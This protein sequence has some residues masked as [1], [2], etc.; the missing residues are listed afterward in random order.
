MAIHCVGGNGRTGTVLAAL[1]LKEQSLHAEFYTVN[2]RKNS[3]V[4]VFRG[5]HNHQLVACSKHVAQAITSIR[6]LTGNAKAVEVEEQVRSLC[7]YE[8]I[9][10]NKHKRKQAFLKEFN[11]AIEVLLQAIKNLVQRLMS[12]MGIMSVAPKPNTSKIGVPIN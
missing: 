9:L 1:K 7:D 8:R 12:L 11:Q 4:F 5:V 3:R 6:A 10:K 2:A